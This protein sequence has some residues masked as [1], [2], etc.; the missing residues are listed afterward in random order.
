MKTTMIKSTVLAVMT[1]LAFNV[2]VLA[3]GKDPIKVEKSTIAWLGKKVTGEHTG[4]IAFKEGD[5]KLKNGALVGGKFVVDMNSINVTDLEGEYKGKL[6]GHLKSD[7]FFGTEKFPEATFV[8][9]SVK[10]NQVKGDLTIKGHTEK[11]SF[12]LITKDN[13]ISGKVV[14][15]RTKFGIRYG[16]NSFFDNLK[17]KAINDEFELT[18]H[19]VF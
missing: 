9:T 19:V 2:S 10:G 11:E 6:E 17:D 8:I 15:D 14:I 1:F 4:T 12:T 5:V 16:S 18:V 7:D 3:Q 13:T